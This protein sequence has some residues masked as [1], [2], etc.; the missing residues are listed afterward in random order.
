M[1]DFININNKKIFYKKTGN[2]EPII[3]LH[4]ITSSSNSWNDL[5]EDISKIRTVYLIDFR[6]HGFSDHFNSYKWSEFSEDIIFF[7]NEIVGS[8]VDILGHSLGACIAAQ[9][10]SISQKIIKS[11]ILEDPPFFHHNR[12]GIEGISRR[13]KYNLSLAKSYN[14]KEEIIKIFRDNSKL[15]NVKNIENI[16]SNLSYLDYKVLE[17]TIDGSALIGFD[18]TKVIK[19]ISNIKTLLLVGN[20]KKTGDV[21]IKEEVDFIAKNLNDLRIK[22]FD[23]G[24]N[25]HEEKTK[26]FKEVVINFLK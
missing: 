3:L 15:S 17:Q 5:F 18:P 26:E 4:G 24:H 19:E 16:A 25:I 21:I 7:I 23:C 8:K 9:V 10:A 20:E 6:G 11:I 1:N 2:G 14:S 13:F 12:A 22:E